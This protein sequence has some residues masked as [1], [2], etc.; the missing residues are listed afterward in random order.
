MK[1]LTVI[2]AIVI[3]FGVL[4]VL[5]WTPSAQ[6]HPEFLARFQS[7]AFRRAEIDGCIVCHVSARGGGPRNDFG[8][9]FDA[10]GQFITPMLRANFPD[11]FKF[12]TVKLP[13]GVVFD[14][15]DPEGK[16]VVVEKEE[17]KTLVDIAVMSAV[18]SDKPEPLPPAANRMTFFVTSKG[19][20]NGGHLQGLAGADRHCQ[21]LAAAVGAGD[22]TWHAY[23][24][25]SFEN[26]PAIN[27]GDRIGAGPWY[28]AK[29]VL[30]AR[31]PVDLHSPN[32]GISEETALNEMGEKINGFGDQPNLDDV[33]TGTLS[34]GS[35]AVGM[36]CNNWTSSDEGKAMVGHHDRKG[37]GENPSSWNSANA[38]NG[39]SPKA[40]EAS[41]GTGLFYCF[42][43]N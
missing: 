27:A 38:T 32:N 28:N 10:A 21:S 17:Q 31:G 5:N 8:V 3:A 11:R 25:T 2:F 20:G 34:D 18:K 41:G 42:A 16:F 9:A 29:G 6:A 1:R 13:S 4:A 30:I 24:S 22:R 40:L 26:K 15:S 39:C 43:V 12:D 14:F 35:A 7:D 36:T 19:M 33:L 23:L 37:T